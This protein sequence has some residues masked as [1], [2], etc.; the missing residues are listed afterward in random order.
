[1]QEEDAFLIFMEAVDKIVQIEAALMDVK[2][3]SVAQK[4]VD[5]QEKEQALGDAINQVVTAYQESR[6][7]DM[8]RLMT[9]VATYEFRRYKEEI[10]KKFHHYALT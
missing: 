6:V 2:P 8:K 5:L 4:S 9:N 10:G 1:M 3:F 7:E